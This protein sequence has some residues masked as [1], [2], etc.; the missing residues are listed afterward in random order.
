MRLSISD[1]LAREDGPFK[2]AD[3]F[4]EIRH[5]P[6][7]FTQPITIHRSNV[8]KNSLSATWEPFELGVSVIG[9][10]DEPFEITVKGNLDNI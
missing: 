9:G 10:L 5:K 1:K 6:P 8:V 4:L 2:K 7:G 3:P